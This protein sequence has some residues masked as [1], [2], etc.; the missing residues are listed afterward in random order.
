MAACEE[1]LTIGC[2]ATGFPPLRGSKPTREPGVKFGVLMQDL[3]YIVVGW[4]FGLL[5]PRIIDA[6][7]L[8]YRRRSIANAVAAEAKD[9]QYRLAIS[10]F[11]VAQRYGK[12]TRDYIIWLKPKLDQYTGNEPS[13]PIKE[14][15]SSL[16]GADDQ[17][18]SNMVAVGRAEE[19][20]GLSLKRYS[21]SFIESHLSDFASFP[22]HYQRWLHEF[23]NH[24]SILNQEVEGAMQCHQMTWD[25]SITGDNHLLLKQEIA[26]RYFR[27][28]GI[29]QRVCD[30]LQPLIDYDAKKI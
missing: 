19:G 7:Q 29:F 17:T 18:F 3:A 23:R 11:L 16:K 15:V 26:Q 12:V 21:A 6:I 22:M 8:K 2:T 14:L 28:Q 24:L 25:S 27:L 5:S 1:N 10:S 20:L 4:L 9:L 13:K 30:H